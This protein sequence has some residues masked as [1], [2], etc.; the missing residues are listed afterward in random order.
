MRMT[1]VEK[2]AAAIVLAIAGA[3][4]AAGKILLKRYADYRERKAAA[5]FSNDE[6]EDWFE[7]CEAAGDT[8]TD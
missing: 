3:T 5:E 7:E 8:D 2:A 4:A 6:E 1:R